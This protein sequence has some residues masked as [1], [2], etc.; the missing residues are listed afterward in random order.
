MPRSGRP[1]RSTG[2]WRVHPR[3]SDH[4]DAKV[5]LEARSRVDAWMSAAAGLD[6]SLISSPSMLQRRCGRS[7]RPNGAESLDPGWRGD[8]R[9]YNRSLLACVIDAVFVGG[10]AAAVQV[11]VGSADA[12]A[13]SG[14]SPEP[15][16]V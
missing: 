14:L 4:T 3:C 2:R 6:D 9:M 11:D 15:A 5:P 12:Q 8:A 16:A 7:H 1:V 13:G 10:S